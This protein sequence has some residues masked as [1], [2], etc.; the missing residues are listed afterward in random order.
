LFVEG[1]GAA[2]HAFLRNEPDLFYPKNSM[3]PFD[4]EWLTWM[5][6]AFSN[7]VRLA[8]N[9]VISPAHKQRRQNG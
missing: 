1:R 2:K 8:R 5:E 4:L 3:Y 6:L 9:E 7:P